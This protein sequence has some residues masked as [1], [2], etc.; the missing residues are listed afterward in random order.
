[1]IRLVPEKMKSRC[2]GH[3]GTLAHSILTIHLAPVKGPLRFFQA[4]IYCQPVENSWCFFF[5]FFFT[6]SNELEDSEGDNTASFGSSS[7]CDLCVF[8]EIL[9]EFLTV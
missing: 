3:R 2:I 6:K 8:S 9:F 4:V 1:M 5:F 7:E